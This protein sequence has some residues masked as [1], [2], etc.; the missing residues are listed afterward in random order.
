[1]AEA[2]GLTASIIAVLHLTQSVLSVCYDY[3]AALKG[4]SWELTKT[5]DELEGFRTVVQALEPLMREAD[6]SD[7][8]TPNGRLPTLKALGEPKG[9]L[10]SCL[11]DL[12]YLEAKLKGPAWTDELG[13]RR[14]A[15]LQ[16]LRW[17]LQEG[18]TK[19]IL[20]RIVRFKDT[21]AT[22]F[23]MDHTRLTLAILNLGLKANE[24]LLSIKDLMEDTRDKAKVELAVRE[25]KEREKEEQLIR[26][27]L[28][29]PDPS[30]NHRRAHNQFMWWKQ[31]KVLTWLYGIP[32]CGKTVLS[33]T[34]IETIRGEYLLASDT[35]VRYFYFDFNDLQ[36][37]RPEYMVRSLLLQ[38][39]EKSC[40][41]FEKVKRL[42]ASCEEGKSPPELDMLKGILREIIEDFSE[43]F[44]ILDALDE[45][46]KREEL[47]EVVNDIRQNEPQITHML[48]TSRHLPDIEEA[49]CPLL[50]GIDKV[51][52][53]G[54]AVTSDILSYINQRLRIDQT[55]KRW[56]NM[57][58]VQDEIRTTLM[59]KAD[60]ILPALRKALDNLP[61]SLDETYSRILCSIP[62][63]CVDDALNMLQWLTFSSRPLCIDELAEVVLI[64]AAG[65]PLVDREAQYPEPSDVLSI[66]SSFVTIE[67][68]PAEDSDCYKLY[69]SQQPWL[70]DA[71]CRRYVRFVHFSVQ[72]YLTSNRI[73]SQNAKR[74][75]VRRSIATKNIAEATCAYILRTIGE[76]EHP[77]SL[78]L[79]YPLFEYAKANWVRQLTAAN[80]DDISC[81]LLVKLLLEIQDLDLETKDSIQSLSRYRSHYRIPHSLPIDHPLG[82]A[83]K[84]GVAR[85]VQLLLMTGQDINRQSD[86]WG[87]PL[88]A[89]L[90]GH[91]DESLLHL[92]LAQG[93]DVSAKTGAESKKFPDSSPLHIAVSQ[94]NMPAVC[95]LLEHGADANAQGSGGTALYIACKARDIG[96]V[97]LLL[98][99]DADATLKVEEDRTPLTAVLL[100]D[101]SYHSDLAVEPLIKLLLER[102]ADA[103]SASSP[104]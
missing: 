33:S 61:K 7:P 84:F 63:E 43:T 78:N 14:K 64:D 8:T 99:H 73:A 59:E 88:H 31:Q 103:N 1:M 85:L 46:S 76:H 75:T 39:S 17:P 55:L 28:S 5:K 50:C 32:G 48:L 102:G 65:D 74:F 26:D 57:P 80:K 67:G 25:S 51:R 96:T 47:F 44:I 30:T 49:L 91:A 19:K 81:E 16:S 68:D 41:A 42:R 24:D 72:E 21:L 4:S 6:L 29:A 97:A 56:R 77:E 71:H 18:D 94:G 82:F 87:S 10:Q 54:D 15:L 35:V 11:A 104:W 101:G 37:Q 40:V 93:A 34:I 62:D 79:R 92:L 20:E 69:H 13:P 45:C 60:G 95:L 22:A 66:L 12:R 2:L 90:T 98:K 9:V 38:A 53:G 86:D 89:A 52:V 3:G 100:G 36:K 27:W 70:D 83:A 23:E 58:D